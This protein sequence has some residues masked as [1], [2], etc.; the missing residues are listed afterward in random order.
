VVVLFSHCTRLCAGFNTQLF[1]A[2]SEVI[3]KQLVA[4]EEAEMEILRGNIVLAMLEAAPGLQAKS[5]EADVAGI[6]GHVLTLS[7]ASAADANQTV[8]ARMGA[9]SILTILVDK[10]AE[11]SRASTPLATI[12]DLEG[13]VRSGLDGMVTRENN[14]VLDEP[15]I[16]SMI[17]A[18]DAKVCGQWTERAAREPPLDRVSKRMK[19]H[20]VPVDTARVDSDIVDHLIARAT[21]NLVEHVIQEESNHRKEFV[22][23]LE[24]DVSG[25][26]L[27]VSL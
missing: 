21:V 25:C 27:H 5:C 8:V 6:C 12:K 13:L 24:A 23:E 2:F 26:V 3:T 20:I 17:A 22:E 16:E 4:V 7:V 11:R 18:A 14:A 1:Q 10:V 15:T 9:A 19:S